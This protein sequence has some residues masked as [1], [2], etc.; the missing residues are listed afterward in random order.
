VLEDLEHGLR[1]GERRYADNALA[2]LE[3]LFC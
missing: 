3:W 1:T 2:S